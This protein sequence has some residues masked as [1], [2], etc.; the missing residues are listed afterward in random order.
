[1]IERSKSIGMVA[2]DTSRL[3]E[4]AI[5]LTD[6]RLTILRDDLHQWIRCGPSVSFDTI[7]HAIERLIDIYRTFFENG[8]RWVGELPELGRIPGVRHDTAACAITLLVHFCECG[9]A[10]AAHMA[11]VDFY[12]V[13]SHRMNADEHTATIT[14]ANDLVQAF[15]KQMKSEDKSSTP[16]F[17]SSTLH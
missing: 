13:P 7:D 9:F 11:G 1:M 10:R 3:K 16:D 5:S 2:S 8:F 4:A 17:K 12:D 14:F 6:V 15:K